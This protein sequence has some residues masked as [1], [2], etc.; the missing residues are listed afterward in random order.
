MKKTLCTYE[1]PAALHD[2]HRWRD[3]MESTG[4][5]KDWMTQANGSIVVH[6]KGS[7][8]DEVMFIHPI[9]WE[10]KGTLMGDVLRAAM[11]TSWDKWIHFGKVLFTPDQY[12]VISSRVKQPQATLH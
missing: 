10:A 2:I 6:I 4:K 7:E 12:A 9:V 5:I 8:E 1:H 3:G 11:S